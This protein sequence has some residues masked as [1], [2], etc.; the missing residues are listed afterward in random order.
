MTDLKVND[1]TWNLFQFTKHLETKK[2]K[3]KSH[4]RCKMPKQ[5]DTATYLMEKFMLQGNIQS[6]LRNPLA[7]PI[8]QHNAFWL[9]TVHSGKTW[10][11]EDSPQ[12]A[13]FP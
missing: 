6:A 12:P 11:I 5:N 7:F 10:R 1:A 3:Y 13:Y 9:N 2:D 4:E 8:K